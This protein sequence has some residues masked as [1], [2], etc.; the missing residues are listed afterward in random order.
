MKL[1]GYLRVSTHRQSAGFSLKAQ[2]EAI[3]SYCRAHRH[4]LVS[5]E[6]ESKSA[7]TQRPVFEQLYARLL[8]PDTT[9]DG[10][11]V[12]KLD[13]LGRSVQDL[14]TIVEGLRQRKQQFISVQDNI[15]TSTPNGKLLFHLLAAIAEYER[16]LLL[17]RTKQG[18]AL[19]EQQGKLCHRPKKPIDEKLLHS[20]TAQNVSHR[21]LAKALGIA[22]STLLQRLDELGLR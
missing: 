10:L 2:K 21:A 17:E 19:A 14:V 8:Q 16:E 6:A 5:A 15:D 18:R 9:L 11:I 7:L 4:E 12:A 20:L 1:A 13:R 22:R 3:A